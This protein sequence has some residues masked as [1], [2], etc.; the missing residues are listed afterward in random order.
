MP[1]DPATDQVLP[2]IRLG[3]G[4]EA[5]DVAVGAGR[6][7]VT[8]SDGNL[9]EVDPGTHRLLHSYPVGGHLDALTIGFGS[10]WVVDEVAGKISR[11][12]PSTGS[13]IR[14]LNVGGNVRAIVAGSGA[15]WVMDRFSGTVAAIDPDTNT[16][17]AAIRVGDRPTGMAVGAGAVWVS[18]SGGSL[19]QVD[20][21]TQSGIE[22]AVG[23]LLTAIAFDPQAG[24]L[25]LCVGGGPG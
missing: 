22:I 13:L 10:V 21:V 3:V 1:I 4:A 20:P 25:W 5:T 6:V 2:T 9:D 23:G 17:G 7:W 18:D 12:D 15:V 8:L 14:A 11:I 16:L 24:N 19:W